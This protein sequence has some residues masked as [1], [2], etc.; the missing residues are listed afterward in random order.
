MELEITRPEFLQSAGPLLYPSPTLLAYLLVAPD[1]LGAGRNPAQEASLFLS[2][3][4]N[5]C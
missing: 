1:A 5:R 2:C 3:G 4:S